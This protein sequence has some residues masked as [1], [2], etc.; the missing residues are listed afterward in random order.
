MRKINRFLVVILALV[1]AVGGVACA[2]SDKPDNPENNPDGNI[3]G[4]TDSYIVENGVSEYKIVIPEKFSNKEEL[5]ASEFNDIFRLSTGIE[6]PV[7]YDASVNYKKGDKYIFIGLTNVLSSFGINPLKSEIGEQGY[8]L[9]TVDYS[10]VLTGA[11]KNGYGTLYAVYEFLSYQVSFECYAEDEVFVEQY[12]DSKLVNVDVKDKP[13]IANNVVCGDAYGSDM[14]FQYRNRYINLTN[15]LFVGRTTPYHSSF[16]YLPKSTYQSSHPYWY[17]P[18]GDQICYTARGD[19]Q[20]YQA[21]VDELFEIFLDVVKENENV[22]HLSFNIEDTITFCSCSACDEMKKKYGAYSAGCIIL[23]NNISTK[24]EEARK[25]DA[26]LADRTLDFCFFAYKETYEA[27]AYYDNGTQ[28]YVPAAPE[29]VCRD[30]VYPFVCTFNMNRAESFSSPKNTTGMNTIKAWGALAKSVAFWTYTENYNDYLAP[31]DCITMMQEN[32]RIIAS[33]N[34]I[35]YKEE[36]QGKN[37]NGTGFMCL[38][39]WLSYKLA[40]D[41]ERDVD[42]LTD[43]YFDHYFQDAKEP[44]KKFYD[45]FTLTLR[46]LAEEK[47]YSQYDNINILSKDKF[48]YGL[49][50]SWSLYIEEAYRSIEYLK[51]EN[52]ALYNKL[53]KRIAIES[54]TIDYT[55]ISL[56]G[57]LFS[58]Q[59]LRDKIERFGSDAK[60]A[61]ISYWDDN[62]SRLVQ[63]FIDANTVN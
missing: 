38:K 36:S 20:E 24:F 61:N 57:N 1:M 2:E 49:L 62:N 5:A 40:W 27:P 32:Y 29:V 56:Y 39:Y 60:L 13:D 47:N 9:K 50:Y 19:E 11:T 59:E 17:S 4:T 7:L 15:D 58:T 33:L 26:D 16:F 6:L 30:D 44:M 22:Q 46:K 34:P 41:T 3:I 10:V 42:K 18:A 14:Q 23:L 52:E 55:M 35:F 21:L 8:I 12:K 31:R 43:E 28:K 63:D 25:T 54:I 51:N 37:Y 53:R 45:S 48:P